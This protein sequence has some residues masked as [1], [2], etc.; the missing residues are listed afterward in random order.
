MQGDVGSAFLDW[1]G[2]AIASCSAALGV[3]KRPRRSPKVW[4]PLRAWRQTLT[5]TEQIGKRRPHRGWGGARAEGAAMRCRANQSKSPQAEANEVRVPRLG[6][7]SP[8]FL[9]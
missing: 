8:D 3:L 2:E 4:E 1:L 9:E 5:N 7:G 6:C